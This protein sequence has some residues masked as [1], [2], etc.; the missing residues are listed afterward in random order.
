MNAVKNL[1]NDSAIRL[2]FIVTVL[3]QHDQVE[4]YEYIIYKTMFTYIN[5]DILNDKTIRIRYPF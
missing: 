4:M 3:S 5:I 1:H 2:D